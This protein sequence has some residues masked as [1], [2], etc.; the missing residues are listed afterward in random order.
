MTQQAVREH[1]GYRVPV[2]TRSQRFA[3]TDVADFERPSSRELVWKNTPLKR[4]EPV[5]GELDGSPAPYTADAPAGV[6]IA[7]VDRD[8]PRVGSS[9]TKPEDYVSALAWSRFERALAVDIPQ[10]AELASPVV[11]TRAELGSTPRAA[12]TVITAGAHSRAI[13]VLENRGEANLAENV[14]I[15]A[16]P[17]ANLTV[18][19]LQEWGDDAVHDAE[20]FIQVGRGAN[21]RHIEV[22][23][24]GALVRVNPSARFAGPGANV[25]LDGV[26]FADAHQFLEQQV[27]VDHNEPNCVSRV[28]YKGALQGE[29]A[30]SAWVGD[31]LIR[32]EAEGTDTYEQ[33]RNLLLTLGARA[34]SVPNLEI[35][36]G[37]IIGAG[38]ASATGRFDEEQ[39]FYFQA[40]GISEEE[41][42]RMVVRG[43]LVEVIQRIGHQPLEERLEKAIEAELY[44]VPLTDVEAVRGVHR[45]EEE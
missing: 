40:R 34:D 33:N 19:T 20:H 29:G 31:V 1:D 43:F 10:D 32:A 25:E 37:E 44:R 45:A 15:V 35:E 12:H 13:V 30:R 21:V 5:L 6:S 7:W 11:I 42:K 9:H 14:E 28:T 2:Q 8:D 26:Y 24:G 18:V 22:N 36:T 3:S 38:H 17:E 16:G 41:A 39:L 27:Y 23:L 4:L